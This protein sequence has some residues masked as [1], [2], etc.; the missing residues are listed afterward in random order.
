MPKGEVVDAHNI[1][2]IIT[3]TTT[4]VAG[5]LTREVILVPKHGTVFSAAGDAERWADDLTAVWVME[6]ALH[7]WHDVAAM[8][9]DTEEVALQ[10]VSGTARTHLGQLEKDAEAMKLRR[11]RCQCGGR[12]KCGVWERKTR[13]ELTQRLNAVANGVTMPANLPNILLD[14]YS[15]WQSRPLWIT[16]DKLPDGLGCIT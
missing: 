7:A 6:T 14:R 3:F 5:R 2:Q 10:V 8:T 9:R 1:L 4:I 13:E 15:H 12:C 11:A 16:V